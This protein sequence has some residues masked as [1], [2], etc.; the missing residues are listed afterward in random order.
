MPQPPLEFESFDGGITDYFLSARLN[1]YEAADN[2]Q[3]LENKKFQTRY[4]S[5]IYD[6][7][8]YQVPIGD[9]RIGSTTLFSDEFFV[10]SLRNL[11]YPTTS[12]QTLLGPSSNPVLASQEETNYISRAEWNGHLTVVSDSFNHPQ[13]IYRD[14]NG[15]LQ[16]RNAGLPKVTLTA[17]ITLANRLKTQYN[18][19]VSNSNGLVA[20]HSTADSTNVVTS[21]D[22]Y[23]FASLVTL[24]SELLTDYDAH[25]DDAQL[26]AG[27]VFHRG[28]GTTGA[29]TSTQAPTT[30]SEV[31]TRINDLQTKYNLHE[32]N[33]TPHDS[34][35]T[36]QVPTSAYKSEPTLTSAG[37]TGQNF[38]YTFVAHYRY[39]VGT[40]YFED[41]GPTHQVTI[42]NVGAPN[43]NTISIS[44][45][46]QITNGT[47]E[48]W[49][50]ANIE[51]YI[52]RTVNSGTTHYFL[53]S[54]TNGT[55]TYSDTTSDSTLD[56]NVQIYTAG[57]TLDN[58]T[59]VPAKFV[60]VANDITWYGH[61][62]EA[63]SIKKS[64][65]RQSAKFDPDS[66][67]ESSFIDVD[68]EITGMSYVNIYP[69]VFCK[70]HIYRLEGFKDDQ[71]RGTINKREISRTVG[72]INNNSIVIVPDGICFAST[73]GFYWTD[74]FKVFK[75]SQS[76]DLR[77]LDLVDTASKRAR[78][79]GEYDADNNRVYWA[80][81]KDGANDDN[82]I[83]YS[84]ELSFGFRSVP[85]VSDAL[86]STFTELKPSSDSWSPT[87]LGFDENGEF[88]IGDKR[89][90]LFKFSSGK[91]NDPKVDTTLTPTSWLTSAIVYD[92][93]GPAFNCGSNH[94]KKI[95][96]DISV[97]IENAGNASIQIKER[98]DQ[99]GQYKNLAEIRSRTGIVWRD[100][101]AT[102]W[103]A[104]ATDPIWRV[105][106]IISE[107][108]NFNTDPIRFI[109][110]QVRITNALTI[111]YKS[112]TMGTGTLDASLNTLSLNNHP[113]FTWSD[114]VADYFV[115][116]DNDSYVE[117]YDVSSRTSSQVIT[118][119]DPDNDLTANSSTKKWVIRGIA[120]NERLNLVSYSINWDFVSDSHKP[121]RGVTGGNA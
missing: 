109:Y 104:D 99:Y 103:R 55:T 74:G 39:S 40:S 29:L 114:D 119:L 110:K 61:V 3:V 57:G 70:K 101:S 4:G 76:F 31:V 43:T 92:Y 81:H 62:K 73:K 97:V 90:Y 2:L 9:S 78:I 98:H 71:G 95:S 21:P 38:I 6:S 46:P 12:W 18:L 77:Y 10:Q 96:P 94:V 42:S 53:G 120:K 111:L 80:C 45:I 16:V 52:Y 117:I 14:I 59:P 69:I 85:G 35:N 28:Q 19:H 11:Y 75:I 121:Y 118:F 41:F 36:L 72:A 37:G 8:M 56:D 84:L 82:D 50:T 25:D 105:F 115:S 30:L 34:E 44:L 66:C 93:K 5:E 91:Y 68:D 88:V 89:G 112:D 107:K 22:A 87:T 33:A 51:W 116:F 63:A 48:N 54:V 13:K 17:C 1:Q 100:S 7:T 83:I 49:D 65:I 113:T 108:R 86:E 20:Y 47:T 24:V 32:A 106:P 102:S 23:D 26:A 67:P 58:D 79:Y 15:V 64:R 27:W 60:T